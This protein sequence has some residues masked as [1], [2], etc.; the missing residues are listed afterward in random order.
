MVPA[1]CG[2]NW[3][4][5]FVRSAL[6]VRLL[7]ASH[8]SLCMITREESYVDAIHSAINDYSRERGSPELE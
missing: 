2:E 7:A 4:R 6:A 5:A 8:G 1:A 3:N